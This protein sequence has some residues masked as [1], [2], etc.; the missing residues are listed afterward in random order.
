MEN[1]IIPIDE[2]SEFEKLV[3]ECSKCHLQFYAPQ[4]KLDPITDAL[5]CKNCFGSPGRKMTVIKDRP[6]RIEID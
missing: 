3:L 4:L 6:P 5:V 1:K 2:E